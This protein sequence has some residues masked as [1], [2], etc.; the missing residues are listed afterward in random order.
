[1]ASLSIITVCLNAV[2]G[3]KNTANSIIHQTDD[4]IEWIVVDG[5][6]T[7]GT[8]EY[9]QKIKQ[10]STLISEKDAGIYNAMNKGISASNGDYCLFLNAGDSLA[11]SDVVR[12]AR[13]FMKKDL[14]IG[15]LRVCYPENT[16]KNYV[17][18]FKLQDI[19]TKYLYYRSLPHPS[20]FIKKSLFETF[21]YYDESFSIAGDHDFFARVLLLG[22]N[23]SFIPFC[24]SEFFM[25]GISTEMKNSSLLQ[26]ELKKIRKNNFT[27]FYRVMRAIL[28]G[29]N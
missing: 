10:V 4:D 26:K 11:D 19:R 21:G 16:E 24:V 6:S 22:V 14:A 20:T 9:L 7:D 18:D 23:K 8:L 3:I 13:P 2:S 12:K 5:Q 27:F 28:G 15:Q 1:M 17:N 25:D 29:M